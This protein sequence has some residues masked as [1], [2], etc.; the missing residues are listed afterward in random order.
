MLPMFTLQA[1]FGKFRPRC[2]F[3]RIYLRDSSPSTVTATQFGLI[4]LQKITD[5]QAFPSDHWGLRCLLNLAQASS[6]G[7]KAQGRKRKAE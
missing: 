4:G 5:T 7:E 3:D 2:R 6:D 1:N